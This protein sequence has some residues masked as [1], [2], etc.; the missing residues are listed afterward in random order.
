MIYWY[1]GCKFFISF[2][3]LFIVDKDECKVGIYNC[4]K[5]IY[6]KNMWGGF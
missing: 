6:C 1:G 5:K 3:I 2:V 4:F